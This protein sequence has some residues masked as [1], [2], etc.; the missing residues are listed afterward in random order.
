MRNAA[1]GGR[2]RD[3]NILL[4]LALALA[5]VGCGGQSEVSTDGTTIF[6]HGASLL[7]RGGEDA[8]IEGRLVLRDGCVVLEP[9]GLGLAYPVIWPSGTSIVQVEPLTLEL[10]SG[11]ELAIGQVVSG[12]GGYHD[13]ASDRVEVDVPAECVPETG[14]VAVFNPDEDPSV[15]E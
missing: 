6:V 1:D 11:D 7:P 9:E 13:A 5:L 3:R 8:L 15:V 12:G 4:T 2:R 14:E 10:P